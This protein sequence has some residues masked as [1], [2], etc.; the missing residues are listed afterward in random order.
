VGILNAKSFE[1]DFA[2]RD[3]ILRELAR[4]APEERERLEAV[5]A[6][7]YDPSWWM[8][9]HDLCFL[10]HERL[11]LPS[12]YWAGAPRQRAAPPNER[13][14]IWL[15]PECAESLAM[16]ILRDVEELR[17]GDRETATRA[18]RQ[19]KAKHPTRSARDHRTTR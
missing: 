11:T 17:T 16:R 19:W 15:H 6:V 18:L 9:F 13:T 10:C 2:R 14:Q 12:V 5:C 4:C 7:D 1:F 3:A 8:E